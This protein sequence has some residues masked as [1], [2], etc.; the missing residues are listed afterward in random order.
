M[1][2]LAVAQAASGPA[3]AALVEP[4][5]FEDGTQG[6]ECRHKVSLS[7]TRRARRSVEAKIRRGLSTRGLTRI[8]F[9]GGLLLPRINPSP[10]AGDTGP[11]SSAG[12][13]FLGLWFS[14][15]DS[16]ARSRRL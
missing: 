15:N 13:V 3:I 16:I 6:V 12:F 4:H 11:P 8:R 14:E 2:R 1:F 7:E 5:P 9:W 10:L